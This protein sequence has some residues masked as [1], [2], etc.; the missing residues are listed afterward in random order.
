M[1]IARVDMLRL[2]TVDCCFMLVHV[3]FLLLLLELEANLFLDCGTIDAVM[4]HISA[5]TAHCWPR[6][7]IPNELYIEHLRSCILEKKK[8]NEK[9]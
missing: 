6:S 1:S 8:K 9:K 4:A 2:I 3:Y 5:A 7:C